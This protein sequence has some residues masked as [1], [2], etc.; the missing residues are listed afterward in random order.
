M[1]HLLNIFTL[2]FSFRSASANADSGYGFRTTRSTVSTDA[3]RRRE[4]E[5]LMGGVL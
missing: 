4:K 1:R 3:Q 2:I 5:R